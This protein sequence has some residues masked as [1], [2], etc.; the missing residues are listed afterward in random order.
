[1][2]GISGEETGPQSIAAALSIVLLVSGSTIGWGIGWAN[3]DNRASSGAFV[4]ELR[5]DTTTS[6]VFFA[7]TAAVSSGNDILIKKKAVQNGTRTNL[8]YDIDFELTSNSLSNF[9][10]S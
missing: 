3:I 6:G 1:M 4:T 9:T 10:V 5:K 7:A 8:N 2:A